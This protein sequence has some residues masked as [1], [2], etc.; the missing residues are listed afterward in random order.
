M[1]LKRK[2]L[3][4]FRGIFSDIIIMKRETSDSDSF[5]L[6]EINHYYIDESGSG[7]LFGKRGKIL[8]GTEGVSNFFMLGLI[9]LPDPEQIQQLLQKLR[10]S[11]LKDPYLNRIPS[12]LPTA[13][14]TALKF[15]A[16]D[17]VPEVRQAVFKMI[18]DNDVHFSAVVKDMRNVLHYA[19]R[20]RVSDDQYRYNRNE[21]YDYTVRWL[22]KDR[23]HK[24]EAYR[25]VFA[26]R[27]YKPG[28]TAA[29]EGQIA[30]ARDRFLSKTGKSA[31][32]RMEV[33]G[34]QTE[35]YA[36]LQIVDYCLWAL[37][38]LYERGEARYLEYIADKISLIVDIDDK[39]E[40]EYGM[41]Y[42]RKRP[43]TSHLIQT[44]KV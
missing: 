30:L 10:L 5:E 39:Q 4:T 41:Y 44:R 1:H 22:L 6:P 16:K 26:N 23:L 14:K 12:I 20:R 28:R 33:V 36:G 37:Q 42:T 21:L 29:L 27:G 31:V 40:N 8:L 32:S 18:R 9:H 34:A 35:E 11:I 38:R 19:K 24:S 2:A 7:D 17:D 43:P 3:D 15:H 13:N 25:I